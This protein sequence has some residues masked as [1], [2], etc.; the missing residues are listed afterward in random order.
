[1]SA[2]LIRNKDEEQSKIQSTNDFKDG[3]KMFC[4][5][6]LDKRDAIGRK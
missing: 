2:D 1:M 5:L 6:D 3:W 4:N